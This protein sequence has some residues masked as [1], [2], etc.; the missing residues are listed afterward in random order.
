MKKKK[1]RDFD[2][3]NREGVSCIPVE[4]V[5]ALVVVDVLL[6]TKALGQL[7]T[8]WIL[9]KVDGGACG[10]CATFRWRSIVSVRRAW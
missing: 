6:S 4:G 1:N 8:Q 10:G 2:C 5:F 9:L 3:K 7:G